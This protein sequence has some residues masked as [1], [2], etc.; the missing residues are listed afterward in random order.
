MCNENCDLDSAVSALALAFF[1]TKTKADHCPVLNMSRADY[2]IKT[3]VCFFLGK[4]GIT[5]EFLTF[6]DEVNLE[7][8]DGLILVDHHVSPFRKYVTEVFDHHRFDSS[9]EL[10]ETCKTTIELVGSCATLIAN[11][12]LQS[13]EP[14][15]GCIITAL[16]MLYGAII[17][18]TLNFSKC[19][20]LDLTVA[21]QI[22]LLTTIDREKLFMDLVNARSDISSLTTLQ[23][24]YKDMKLVANGELRVGISSLPISVQE[25]ITKSPENSI[26]LF[27]QEQN[28]NVIVLMGMQIGSTVLRDIGVINISSQS[29]CD[30]IALKIQEY[31]NELN[32]V[33][34]E[35]SFLGGRFFQQNI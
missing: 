13:P 21:T 32:L 27:A 31:G 1:Y 14:K 8:S 26:L 28:C 23:I 35:S 7:C 17:L 33:E 9:S 16:E 24:L 12:I 6:K 5:E 25:F 10:N 22:E 18:D 19:T 2:H 15:T 3:E 20:D 11:L 34:L 29:L 4:Y 30:E